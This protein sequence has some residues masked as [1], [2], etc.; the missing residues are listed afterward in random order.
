MRTAFWLL[1]LLKFSATAHAAE[2]VI[3]DLSDAY[4]RSQALAGLLAEVDAELQAIRA[5]HQPQLQ[6]A[7]QQLQRVRR[8]QPEVRDAQLELA[9][10]I[11][12]I[13]AAV[14]QE[15]E[16]L[17]AANERAI[18]Q[19][20]RAIARAKRQLAQRLQVPVVLDIRETHYLRP[21][22]SCERSG[23][24]FALLNEL[25]PR[26]SLQLDAAERAA[27]ADSSG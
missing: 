18:A 27:D 9:R 13:E 21:G 24:L 8:E 6:A 20:D 15:E 12:R 1:L 25:L 7:R 5:R 11:A 16:A 23:E 3:V 19:V 4:T 14:E 22:C 26:V 10:R 17:A 2:V